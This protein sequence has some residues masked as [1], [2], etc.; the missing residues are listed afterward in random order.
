MLWALF[1]VDPDTGTHLSWRPLRPFYAYSLESVLFC[2]WL[3][4]FCSP[5]S[6]AL[7][8]Y[9]RFPNAIPSGPDSK[10]QWLVLRAPTH[11]ACECFKVAAAITVV[12]I[13]II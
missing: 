1:F 11:N 12:V 2:S 5:M 6:Q 4:R 3:T 9:V 13:I 8:A 7:I 10:L